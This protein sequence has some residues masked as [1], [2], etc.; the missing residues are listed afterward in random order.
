PGNQKIEQ[1]WF[2]GSHSNVGGGYEN[3]LLAQYPL[4][5]MI[6]A[7]QALNLEFRPEAA[8]LVAPAVAMV[9]PLLTTETPIKN[10]ETPPPYLRDSYAEFATPL[11]QYLIRAKRDYRRLAPP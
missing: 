6:D 7:C 11:W 9:T 5:W 2:V 3:D 8:L 4:R 10:L 1:R